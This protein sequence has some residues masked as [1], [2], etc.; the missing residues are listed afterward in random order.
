M[1]S[2]FHLNM[3]LF[4]P[5]HCILYKLY[6]WDRAENSTQFINSLSDGPL[7]VMRN[8]SIDMD[9]WKSDLCYGI[10][11][12]QIQINEVNL[13]KLDDDVLC[14]LCNLAWNSIKETLAQNYV[15]YIQQHL[16]QN[17]HQDHRRESLCIANLA[18]ILLFIYLNFNCL[19]CWSNPADNIFCFLPIPPI[20]SIRWAKD[21]WWESDC[22]N[23][24]IV[25]IYGRRSNGH[26]IWLLSIHQATH[27]SMHH[28]FI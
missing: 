25:L 9:V 3:I 20:P 12:F 11:P 14:I 17:L 8:A 4:H 10:Y 28:W 16:I 18:R 22:N 24:Q 5:S 23:Q 26:M 21:I 6:F 13:F 27:A 7:C 15:P 19:V 1:H 2:C